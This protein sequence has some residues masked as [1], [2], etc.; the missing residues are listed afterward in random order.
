MPALLREGPYRFYFLSGDRNEP[1]HVHV[2]RDRGYA[3]FWLSPVTMQNSGHFSSRELR[4]IQRIVEH[5]C[6]SFLEE[7]HAY[8]DR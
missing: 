7:W 6:Q 2:R 4:H 8:F 1:P 5:N 3:K